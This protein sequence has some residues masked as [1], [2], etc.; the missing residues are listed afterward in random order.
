[1]IKREENKYSMYQGIEKILNEEEGAVATIPAFTE[2]IKNFREALQNISLKDQQY[3]NASKGASSAKKTAEE[4]LIESL[5]VSSAALY[6]LAR[7]NQD[8]T[9]KALSKV[10]P[11]SLRKMRDNDLLQRAISISKA[12]TANQEQL[13]NFG[14]NKEAVEDLKTKVATYEDLVESK[15]D[16]TAESKAARQ[17]LGEFFDQADEI[18][19]EELDSM[20]ELI[21][22]ND[23]DFY[24]RYQ[25]A[26]VIKDI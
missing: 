14:V 16:K 19:Y 7:R 13:P 23:S 20:V 17:E 1:M 25:A 4:E 18:L 26:R 12:V 2:S 24:N 9:L 15:E 5:I 10:S 22:N 8:E 11:S 6:V 21:K 3:Q